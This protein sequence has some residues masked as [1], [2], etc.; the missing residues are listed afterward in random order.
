MTLPLSDSSMPIR[1]EDRHLLKT[2]ESF[3]PAIQNDRTSRTFYLSLAIVRHYLGPE[4]A[5]EYVQ[6][7]GERGYVRLD[8]N[9]YHQEQAYRIVDLA[10]LLLNLQS[11]V[12]FDDC[13][14]RMKSGDIEATYAELDLGRMLFQSDIDFRFVSTTGKKGDDYDLEIFLGDGTVLCAD[15]KCK[16]EATDFSERTVANSLH[17]ARTS[18]FRQPNHV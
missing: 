17:Q 8:W 15:A 18:I 12:G 13:I 5:D 1:L 9:G 2:I 16:I 11:I 4:W 10:E 6:D 14:K 3:P 7:T